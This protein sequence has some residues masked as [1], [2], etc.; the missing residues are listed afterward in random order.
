MKGLP[1]M[2]LQ[3]RKKS[4]LKVPVGSNLNSLNANR[5]A[6]GEN[7]IS[8]DPD[9]GFEDLDSFWSKVRSPTGSTPD[10]SNISQKKTR[11]AKNTKNKSITPIDQRTIYKPSFSGPGNKSNAYASGEHSQMSKFI[12][13]IA[14]Q[15]L[16]KNVKSNPND[17]FSPSTI[18]TV[19]TAP[20]S[21][22]KRTHHIETPGTDASKQLNDSNIEVAR[23]ASTF[24]DGGKIPNPIKKRDESRKEEN[25][26]SSTDNL[27]NNDYLITQPNNDHAQD[28]EEDSTPLEQSVEELLN[29]T[30]AELADTGL[31]NDDSGSYGNDQEDEN[32]FANNEEEISSRQR[33]Q[34]K[35]S[36]EK[37]FQ[38]IQEDKETDDMDM[39][40]DFN[41]DNFGGENDNFDD[42]ED[43]KEG[44]GFQMST[45]TPSPGSK[46]KIELLTNDDNDSISQSSKSDSEGPKE[47][48]Q[49]QGKKR[50]RPLPIATIND[51]T[52][53]D[54]GSNREERRK[55]KKRRPA[56]VTPSSS[57]IRFQTGIPGP[58]EYDTIPADHYKNESDEEA[59][60]TGVRRSRR[61][62]FPPLQFWKNE[63][64]V[65]KAN[66]DFDDEILGDMPVVGAVVKALPT[67][68]K[69]RK[70]ELITKNTKKRKVSKKDSANDSTSSSQ[71]IEE[72]R[73]FD[74]TRLRK[75]YDILDGEVADIWDES[76]EGL[77]QR[78]VV[79]HASK[80]VQSTLPITRKRDK[81]ESRVLCSASQA[82]NI[83]EA[84]ESIPGWIS[85]HLVLPPKGIKDAE[86][87]GLCSQVFCVQTCQPNSLEVS[88][89]DPDDSEY[90][91]D[92]AQ[93]FLL[94]PGDFFHVPANN[95]YRIENHSKEI[96][97]KLFFTIIR[98]M[99]TA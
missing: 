44:S 79:C 76:T 35:E 43:D 18:S 16:R 96:E 73:P 6:G 11:Q 62:K 75:K 50:Q 88:L 41:N 14:R 54:E 65:Y 77:N 71:P 66:N 80:M 30:A 12:T 27:E 8:I 74:D 51:D 47:E 9:T 86:G 89:A 83:P 72:L 61:A 15:K 99:A 64:L 81:S 39:D 22:V 49:P 36:Q 91:P 59:E 63:K 53:S 84:T 52:N 46:K 20:P 23:N 92:T 56:R 34:R 28:Y 5:N 68:Y 26:V 69:K 33:A 17:T 90:D 3:D 48:K 82:F 70:A 95:V 57:Q 32:K 29:S 19:S 85:G 78:K 25:S 60:T 1:A 87:V 37:E 38:K 24:S 40:H 2:S 45:T 93:R 21:S 7:N 94:N 98:P 67:P 13:S 55:K 58:R 31:D 10:T 97:G 42:D 4:N